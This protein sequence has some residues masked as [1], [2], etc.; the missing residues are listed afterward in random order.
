MHTATVSVIDL[1][2]HFYHKQG[3]AQNVL[4]FRY[5]T[6]IKILPPP[7]KFSCDCVIPTVNMI[8]HGSPKYMYVASNT[9]NTTNTTKTHYTVFQ[10]HNLML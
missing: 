2:T 6:K 4:T 3:W 9:S 1:T 8:K 5:G 7:A 10:K